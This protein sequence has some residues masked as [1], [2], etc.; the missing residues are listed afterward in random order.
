MI[1]LA[2]AFGAK[3]MRTLELLALMHAAGHIGMKEIDAMVAY[4]RHVNDLPGNW[5][6]DYRRLFGKKPP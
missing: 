1:A 3:V 4:W 6:K 2:E 5:A